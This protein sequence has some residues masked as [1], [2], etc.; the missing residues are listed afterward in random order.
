MKIL[1]KILSVILILL[2]PAGAL[3]GVLG[4]I[5]FN[6]VAMIAGGVLIG[7]PLIIELI[8]PLVICIDD[9]ITD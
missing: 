9:I 1:I 2:V 3:T 4:L 5:F 6:E 8:V 7:I